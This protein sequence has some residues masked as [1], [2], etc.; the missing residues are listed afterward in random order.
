MLLHFATIFAKTFGWNLNGIPDG[1]FQLLLLPMYNFCKSGKINL[2]SA[3]MVAAAENFLFTKKWVELGKFI[4]S[5]TIL[6]QK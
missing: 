2:P 3:P 1:D 6:P 4:G 5:Y